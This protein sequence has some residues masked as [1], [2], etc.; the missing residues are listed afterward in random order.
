MATS[1]SRNSAK[2]GGLLRDDAANPSADKV[3]EISR[4]PESRRPPAADPGCIARAGTG[5]TG[6]WAARWCAGICQP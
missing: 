6:A 1:I 3:A 5:D 4:F 2:N